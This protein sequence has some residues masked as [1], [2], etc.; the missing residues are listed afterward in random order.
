M[1]ETGEKTIMEGI[2]ENWQ[3]VTALLGTVLGG[4]VSYIRMDGKVSLNK[5]RI[6]HGFEDRKLIETD[7][8][9]HDKKIAVIEK[10]IEG[11]RKASDRHADAVEKIK[12]I[13]MERGT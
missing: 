7:V 2:T 9:E 4:V 10:D 1:I 6:K 13:L 12:D 8:K 3:A 11:I 5:E